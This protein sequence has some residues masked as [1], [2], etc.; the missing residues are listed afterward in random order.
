MKNF[1]LTL[2]LIF[3]L[4]I[5]ICSADN[6]WITQNSGTTNDLWGVYAVDYKNIWAVGVNGTIIHTSNGGCTWFS[7]Y[8]SPGMRLQSVFFTC[9][10]KGIAVGK[11]GII[12]RTTNGGNNWFLQTS[13][14]NLELRYVQFINANTG[15]IVGGDSYTPVIMRTTDAGNSWVMQQG[16]Y[17]I[18][19]KGVFFVDANTGYCSAWL[20][21]I[22]KTTNAGETWQSTHTS[23]SL[24]GLWFTNANTGTIVGYNGTIIRTTDGGESWVHQNPGPSTWYFGC[25]FE[26]QN[27]G[28]VTGYS[29]TLL[30]TVNGGTNWNPILSGITNNL[31]MISFSY[32]FCESGAKCHRRSGTIVG[33]GGIILHNTFDNVSLDQEGINPIS[34]DVPKEYLLKQNYPNPFNPLTNI[35]Y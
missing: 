10:N 32:G 26:N 11:Q 15:T 9:T 30:R 21:E 24:E 22:F 6:G 3:I 1:L 31:Y 13:P 18:G 17:P 16:C 7:Q 2:S 14:T 33:S 34:T 5:K 20:G 29:G 28:Y 25:Y 27:T 35:K 23:Q 8:S 4:S 12:L 19:L